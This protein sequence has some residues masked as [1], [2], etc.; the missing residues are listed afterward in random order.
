MRFAVV[1]FAAVVFAAPTSPAA[2]VVS[3]L[4]GIVARGPIPPVCRV[5]DP[6]DE[7]AANVT[8]TFVRACVVAARVET[9]DAGG[10][11][12]RLAPGTYAVRVRPVS[13]IGSVSPMRVRVIAGRMRRVDFAI[14]TGIR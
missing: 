10:Y 2:R 7:P 1:A 11:R 4:H 13:K 5:D 6:C 8:L 9:G 14:D 12:I 3:G